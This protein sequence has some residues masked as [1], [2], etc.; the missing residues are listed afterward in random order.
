MKSFEA[1]RKKITAKSKKKWKNKIKKTL[2][3]K[4]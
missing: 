3:K 1:K 4:K 2:L